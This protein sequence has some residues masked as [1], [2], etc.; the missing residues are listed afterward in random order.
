MIL[1]IIILVNLAVTLSNLG[2][3]IG[4]LDADIFGPSI[5]LM[6]NLNESPLV[7]SNNFIIPSLNYNVKW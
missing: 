7:D 6:M 2:L 1:C 5:P 3:K 4:L